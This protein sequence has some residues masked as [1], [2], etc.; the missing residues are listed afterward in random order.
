MSRTTHVWA[1]P[2]DKESVVQEHS[3]GDTIATAHL[4]ASPEGHRVIVEYGKKISALNDD[5]IAASALLNL[6]HEI[7]LLA[8]DALPHKAACAARDAA[9]AT[10]FAGHVQRSEVR[11]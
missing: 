1:T 10:T 7:L 2:A 9:E 4:T 11:R 3:M 5:Q 6:A 8:A